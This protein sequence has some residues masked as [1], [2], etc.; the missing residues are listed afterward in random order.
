MRSSGS[1]QSHRRTGGRLA[2]VAL[3][4]GLFV[5]L[6]GTPAGAHPFEVTNVDVWLDAA[7]YRLDITFHVDAM[8]AD[9]PVGDLSE[10]EYRR[11]RAL[12]EAEIDRRLETV[13]QYFATMVA[14]RFDDRAVAPTVTFPAREDGRDG[15][16]TALPGHLVRLQGAIPTGATRFTFRAA[17]VFNLVALRISG[18][19]ADGVEQFLDPLGESSPYLL[20]LERPSPG[21]FAV[22]L[23][24]MRLGFLHI[25]PKGLDHVLFVLGLYLLSVRPGVLIGQVTA[26]TVAHTLTLG[27][28]MYGVL[29]LSP[30][31]VEPLIVLSIAWVAVENLFTSRLMPWRP[32]VVFAFGLLHGLGFAAALTALGLPRDRFV[33]ALV[34]FNAGVEAGQLAVIG[35]AFAAT[36]WWRSH[37]RYRARIVVPA[38]ATIALVAC[39]WA[40]VRTLR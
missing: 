17:P 37:E 1:L 27:L 3:V 16:Q 23:E 33:V 8:L 34:G 5:F 13:R 35:L 28:S 14:V 26:F 40:I 25:L 2:A 20:G 31:I 19:H 21:S 39:Y 32:A 4:T 29:R 9:V 7:T 18:P 24:Y 22:V 11:L 36:G 10:D 30:S 15:A 12:P 6:A 38:S